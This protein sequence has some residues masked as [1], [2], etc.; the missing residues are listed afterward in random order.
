MSTL[1]DLK[2]TLSAGG[3]AEFKTDEGR[4]NFVGVIIVGAVFLFRYASLPD[5]AVAIAAIIKGKPYQYEQPSFIEVLI[6]I[7]IIVAVTFSCILLLGALYRQKTATP[8]PAQPP[9]HPTAT[10]TSRKTS[11]KTS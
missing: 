8:S 10:P 4:V 1:T 5:A 9:T 11:K 6:S 7:A 2:E 3:V